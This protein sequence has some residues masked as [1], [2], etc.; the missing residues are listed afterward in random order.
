MNAISHQQ[1]ALETLPSWALSA[2]V[3][4]NTTLTLNSNNIDGIKTNSSLL[5][6]LDTTEPN[7]LAP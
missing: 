3:H 7:A 2:T 5:L 1:I 6:L 4:S